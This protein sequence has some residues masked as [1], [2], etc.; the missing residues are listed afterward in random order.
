MRVSLILAAILVLIATTSC[1]KQEV[2]QNP[3]LQSDFMPEQGDGTNMAGGEPE[4]LF[5][6]IENYKN[7]WYET[8]SPEEVE[9]YELGFD[10]VRITGLQERIPKMETLV[11]PFQLADSDGNMVELSS[12]TSEG[13]LILFWYLGS[14]NNYCRLTL[15]AMQRIMPKV[16]AA[17]ATMIAIS[18][19][20]PDSSIAVGERFGLDYQLLSDVD[21]ELATKFG[22][23][24]EVPE[25]LMKELRK[26]HPFDSYYK[27]GIKNF[28][29]TIALVIDKDRKIRYVFGEADYRMRAEPREITDLLEHLAIESKQQ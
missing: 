19:Q 20:V 15:A 29:T 16:T 3:Q 4:P 22:I 9:I 23:T 12:L 5:A 8:T 25:S 2:D 14:W 10:A 6:L 1:E 24:Y 11:E 17:G 7:H 21:N 27:K 13:P 26:K 28:P 18:P